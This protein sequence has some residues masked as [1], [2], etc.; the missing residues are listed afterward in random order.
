M[1]RKVIQLA[2]K[3]LLVSLPLKWARKHNVNKGDE[4]ELEEQDKNM[5][6]KPESELIADKTE[7]DVSNLGL[8]A[9]RALGAVFKAGY[10]EVEVKYN[11]ADE[12][13]A[14]QDVVRQEFL[15]F[16]IVYQGKNILR[17]K[18]VSTIDYS[19]FDTILRRMFLII[20][21]VGEDSLL[22]IKQNDKDFL[23]K[24]ILRDRDVNKA[25]DFCRRI[26]NKKGFSTFRKT[27]PMYFI[28]EQL[29]KIADFYKE[30]CKKALEKEKK[31]N[32]ETEA[33]LK[34]T[35]SF[36]EQFYTLFYSFSLEKIADFGKNSNSLKKEIEKLIDNS[37]SETRMLFYLNSIIESTFDMNGALMIVNL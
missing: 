25:S 7:I 5:L 9:T 13:E 35:N 30:L 37:K 24:I 17:I 31:L 15:S 8:M 21:S 16:E 14:I 6:I 34:K 22:A 29:E 11:S 10:D 4:L 1:K 26:L 18:K 20:K 32:P 28:I 3:T 2:G 19:E 27:P 33:M 12:L 23:K 36:F